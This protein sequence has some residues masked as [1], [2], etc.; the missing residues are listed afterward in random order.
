M[1]WNLVRDLFRGVYRQAHRRLVPAPYGFEDSH[2]CAWSIFVNAV[3][4]QVGLNVKVSSFP[5]SESLC[6][7]IEMIFTKIGIPF[8]PDFVPNVI[9]V[10]DGD[11]ERRIKGRPYQALKMIKRYIIQQLRQKSPVT[12]AQLGSRKAESGSNTKQLVA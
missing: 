11:R 7:P 6:Q 3:A 1:S 10:N 8:D 5:P 12:V 2:G 9:L 4:P